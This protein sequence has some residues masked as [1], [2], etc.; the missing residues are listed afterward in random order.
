MD[1]L[2]ARNLQALSLGFHIILVC[3]GVAFPIF[4]L[5]ME[6]LYLRT[7]DDLYRR[8][9]RRW[10][11]AMAIL[12]A[13][14]VVSGTVLSFELG[15]LWPEFMAKYGDVFGFAF[16]LEGTSFFVEAIFMAIYVYGWDRLSER[17]HFLSGLPIPIAGF[18]G[19]LFVISVNG[20]MNNPVGFDEVNGVVSNIN[21]IAA[22]FNGFFWHELV[23]MLLAAIIVA[24]FMTASVYAV[25]MLRGR[26]DRFVRVA[27]IVPLSIAA[28]LMG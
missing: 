2:A 22:L 12:F 26:R 17:T 9:A 13:V 23:H 18:F 11:K 21:P 8:I 14:G 15:I 7:R 16:A 6:G 4:V 19:S 10:T 25:A 28:S 3:F 27:M 1:L 20:W 24:G 5:T